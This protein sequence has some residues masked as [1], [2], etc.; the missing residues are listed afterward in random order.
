MVDINLI[1]DDKTGEEER[2]D[3]FTQ[4]SSMDTQELAFEERTETFDTTKTAGFAQKRS[5][6]SLVSTLIIV[7]VIILLGGSIYFFMFSGNGATDNSQ[8]DIV[9]TPPPAEDTPQ[10]DS[11]AELAKLEKEFAADLATTKPEQKQDQ[12]AIQSIPDKVVQQPAKQQKPA[13]TKRVEPEPEISQN[14]RPVSSDFLSNSKAA[15]QAVTKLISSVP[16]NLNTTLLS[17]TGQH[18]RVEFVAGTA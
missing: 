10:S 15:V 1:G 9:D 5:Y 16:S 13:I 17:Y 7:A 6:S 2:L 4:T 11:D 18:V 12:P 8:V 14:I 3:D